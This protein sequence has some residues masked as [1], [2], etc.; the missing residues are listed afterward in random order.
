MHYNNYSPADVRAEVE[1]AVAALS[2]VEFDTIAVRG[3][4]GMMVGVPLSLELGKP[5]VV[6]RKPEER[7]HSSM[8]ANGRHLGSSYIIVDDFK[9]TGDTMRA[10]RDG[11]RGWADCRCIPVPVCKGEYMY[12]DRRFTPG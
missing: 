11:I 7:A 9:A 2:G 10:V 3:V 12:A 4:S 5:L 8:L 1:A 6:V